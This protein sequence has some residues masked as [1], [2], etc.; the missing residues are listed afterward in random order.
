M[1]MSNL[2]PQLSKL[3]QLRP[4]A[5]V[6]RHV[7]SSRHRLVSLRSKIPLL[8][9]IRIYHAL[10]RWYLSFWV[11]IIP[12]TPHSY[13][14]MEG[15]KRVERVCYFVSWLSGDA[16]YQALNHQELI[17]KSNM[18]DVKS[19]VTTP[20]HALWRWFLSFWVI[21]IPFIPCNYIPMEGRKGILLRKLTGRWRGELTWSSTLVNRWSWVDLDR[22]GTE[23]N[24]FV[25]GGLKL[26]QKS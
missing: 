22:S 9:S 16:W 3:V 5:D 23:L 4:F 18:A 20:G 26:S 24:V 15:R 25:V 11:I 7:G 8:P 19:M 6:A 17:L 13:I 21:I 12:F 1:K 2:F 14:P 10:W